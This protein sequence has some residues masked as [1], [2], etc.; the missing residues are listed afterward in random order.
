MLKDQIKI[1]QLYHI[2]R[3][4]TITHTRAILRP[5]CRTILCIISGDVFNVIDPDKL[6]GIILHLL[7]SRVREAAHLTTTVI[8]IQSLSFLCLDVNSR[9]LHKMHKMNT[10]D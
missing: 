1:M 8:L 7:L 3:K 9:S 2:F 4:Y 5:N 6:G 10:I